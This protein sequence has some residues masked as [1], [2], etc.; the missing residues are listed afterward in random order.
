MTEEKKP[1]RIMLRVGSVEAEIECMED[2]LKDA[3]QNLLSVLREHSK[4][5]KSVETVIV[6]R[7]ETCK[8]IIKGLWREGWFSLQRNLAE[9]CE[10]MSR[11]GYNFD[12]TAVAHALVDLV[13]EGYLTRTGKP[14]RYN[15]LQKRPPTGNDTLVL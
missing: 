5:Q 8:A 6:P 4:T 15:Y 14:R 1:I 13:R 11:R 3:V 12:R 2:Q 7:P 10:E 9:V